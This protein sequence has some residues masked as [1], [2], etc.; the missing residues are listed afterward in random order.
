MILKGVRKQTENLQS[1]SGGAATGGSWVTSIATSSRYLLLAV[2]LSVATL[3]VYWPLGGHAFVL[4][5]DDVYVFENPM[6]RA[7]LS[8]GGI[9][10]ALSTFEGANWHPVTWLS[11][12]TDVS[13]FGLAPGPHHWVNLF[14]H[15][16]N[17]L[18]LFHLLVCMTG[19]T[20]RS[21]LAAAL[22]A[23]HPMH[24]ESVA[25]IAERKD[26]LSALFGLLSLWVYLG[27]ARNPRPGRFLFVLALFACALMSKPML[28][29]LP[30]IFLL[31]D[32]W[33]LGRLFQE[34]GREGEGASGSFRG[35][36]LEKKW[37]FLLSAISCVITVLAQRHG[38]AVVSVEAF[39]VSARLAN[40]A[41]AYVQYLSKMIWPHPLAVFYPNP[42][43]VLE[44][45]KIAG[46][47]LFLGIMTTFA[48]RWGRV[49][50]YLPVGWLWFLGMLVPVIGLVQVGSQSI[51]DRYSY[52]PFIGPFLIVA[53]GGE[54]L[55][56][57]FRVPRVLR[58]ML[59]CTLVIGLS[60][61]ARA[62]VDTWKSTFT[63]FG[64]MLQ[65]VPEG[66]RLG[67]LSLGVAYLRAGKPEE[68]ISQ[69]SMVL[70]EEPRN[71]GANRTLGEIFM[72][73]GMT[74]QGLDRFRI[75]L[76]GKPDDVE[77]LSILGVALGKAGK[78][79]ESERD[80][81]KAV[82]LAPDDAAVRYNLGV[83]LEQK[84]KLDEAIANYRGSLAIDPRDPRTMG[85]LGVALARSGRLSEAASVLSET[86][87]VSP[88][89]RVA[90]ENLDRVLELQAGKRDSQERIVTP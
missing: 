21:A 7:G 57:H 53:W 56:S 61:A 27:Y 3:A 2:L 42:G 75:A 10:W 49:K 82:V 34:G 72:S 22:F 29:T 71:Y 65:T 87:R 14:F 62:Q 9:R 33:P 58:G 39:P 41:F 15:L 4:F 47:L 85:N 36:L 55:L 90:R 60:L 35:L 24:V 5:D 45:W 18:L 44:P 31:L 43:I 89:N 28:V 64:H 8:A 59:A 79:D 67:H 40:A 70:R 1:S 25:W 80:L 12:M 68:A 69:L 16:C 52:L 76:E 63:L 46:S 78:L 54:D 73:Q 77:L 13:L 88:G 20:G 66:S 6:V 32:Y 23:V 50:R 30:F 84:G 51:A 26:L 74:E 86:L 11:H 38:G 19:A 48:F 17:S 37:M 81:R 83:L